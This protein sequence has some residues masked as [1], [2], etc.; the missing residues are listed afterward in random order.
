VGAAITVV[1]IADRAGYETGESLES[2]ATALV[3]TS[4]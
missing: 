1:V 4:S 2:V 3:E